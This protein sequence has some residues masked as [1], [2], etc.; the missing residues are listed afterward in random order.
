[1][2]GCYKGPKGQSDYSNI[3]LRLDGGGVAI[4]VS[5]S[6]PTLLERVTVSNLLPTVLLCRMDRDIC[7]FWRCPSKAAKEPMAAHT[8]PSIELSKGLELPHT[9]GGV[10][11][12]PRPSTVSPLSTTGCCTGTLSS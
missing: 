7:S 3:V 6:P 5:L 11:L 8:V 12:G 9:A 2:V 4:T 10:P 1:M